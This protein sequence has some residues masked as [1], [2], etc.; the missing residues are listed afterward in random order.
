MSTNSIETF[1][2][3]L[4]NQEDDFLQDG[5]RVELIIRG[6]FHEEKSLISF[7]TSAWKAG[8]VPELRQTA[9]IEVSISKI[10]AR[11]CK[12]YGLKESSALTAV[13]VW[14]YGLGLTGVAPSISDD[15]RTSSSRS[16]PSENIIANT[17]HLTAR[18]DESSLSFGITAT[19]DGTE[20]RETSQD[21]RF[22][23]DG[24][25]TVLDKQTGLMWA[26][27]DNGDGVD[28]QTAKSYCEN[29]RGGGFTN[30]R[31]PTPDE[32]AGLH[33]ASKT[34]KRGKYSEYIATDLISL[35]YSIVWS[36]ETY[37]SDAV[38]FNFYINKQDWESQ[39]IAHSNLALPVRSASSNQATL[40]TKHPQVPSFNDDELDDGKIEEPE[41]STLKI[42]PET[43]ELFQEYKS[44]VKKILTEKGVKVG[45]V[46]GIDRVKFGDELYVAYFTVVMNDFDGWFYWVIEKDKFVHSFVYSTEPGEIEEFRAFLRM[47]DSEKKQ[48]LRMEFEKYS[49]FKIPDNAISMRSEV[50]KNV[51]SGVETSV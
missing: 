49:N 21:G 48:Y 45:E 31:M 26:A 17:D 4:K 2:A 35:S 51:I 47:P 15:N 20:D 32:L 16:K 40:G 5:K 27:K 14:V 22:I 18:T 11:L 10:E 28:W 43:K 25:E 44:D 23:A 29:Y 9:N 1:K 3:Y 8:V 19:A 42:D 39:S 7:L 36:S 34:K 33:D 46:K 30:W 41:T 37:R 12:E 24:D 13:R 6:I 38:L 50:Q